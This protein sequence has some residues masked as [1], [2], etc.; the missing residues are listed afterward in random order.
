[1]IATGTLIHKEVESILLLFTIC[2]LIALT[3]RKNKRKSI[4]DL[5]LKV[6]RSKGNYKEILIQKILFLIIYRSSSSGSRGMFI[7]S[8]NC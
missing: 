1:M 2:P 7:A 3:R 5:N 8:R 4:G 6:T